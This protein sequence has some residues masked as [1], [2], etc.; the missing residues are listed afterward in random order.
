MAAFSSLPEP[1]RGEGEHFMDYVLQLV[2]TLRHVLHTD[3]P[4][5]NL[6]VVLLSALLK[7]V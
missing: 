4:I 1:I 5:D 2:G 3:R 6:T 7:S